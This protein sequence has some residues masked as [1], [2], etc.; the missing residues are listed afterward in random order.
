MLLKPFA[1]SLSDI[2]A[3]TLCTQQYICAKVRE[4]HHMVG[5]VLTNLPADEPGGVPDWSQRNARLSSCVSF[6][7]NLNKWQLKK[8]F[9]ILS[10]PRACGGTALLFSH[11]RMMQ[12]K[13]VKWYT[14][15]LRFNSWKVLR[16]SSD[17]EIQQTQDLIALCS[18]TTS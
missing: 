9:Q 18:R 4:W 1:L 7:V 6:A 2:P 11:C 16:C 8:I 17:G 3:P 15:Y 5:H 10:H 14:I 13:K 12:L